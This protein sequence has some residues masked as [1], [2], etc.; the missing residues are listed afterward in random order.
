MFHNKDDNKITQ[1][2]NHD[3]GTT[4]WHKDK[5]NKTLET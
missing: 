5:H 2:H 3:R 1:E 4:N